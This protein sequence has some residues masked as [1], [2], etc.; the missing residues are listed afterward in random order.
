MGF[1][2]ILTLTQEVVWILSEH[3][4]YRIVIVSLRVATTT[5]LK[6]L[7]ELLLQRISID[8]VNEG[9]LYVNSHSLKQL[10]LYKIC[11]PRFFQLAQVGRR[12]L[13]SFGSKDA[14]CTDLVLKS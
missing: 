3:F 9:Y 6:K 5:T 12:F 7:F 11:I 8:L 1:L 10:I 2:R 13:R 4:R 14:E